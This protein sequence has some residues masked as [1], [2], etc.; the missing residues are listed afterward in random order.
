MQTRAILI[1]TAVLLGPTLDRAV[2]QLLGETPVDNV[3]MDLT[4]TPDGLM[5][6][7]RNSDDGAGNGVEMVSV[8][9]LPRAALLLEPGRWANRP[10]W[11]PM[12]CKRRTA[13]PS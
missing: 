5:A 13:A 11:P 3:P 9:H 10:R 12:V 1:L 6:A 2:A 8:W 4:V 7:I